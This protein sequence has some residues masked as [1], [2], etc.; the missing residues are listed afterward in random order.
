MTRFLTLSG[1]VA[2]VGYLAGALSTST[3]SVGP[4]KDRAADRGDD[5]VVETNRVDW[6]ERL[7][8]GTAAES[9]LA[10]WKLALSTWFKRGSR[11][12]NRWISEYLD[13]GPPDAMG[14]YVRGSRTRQVESR[15]G[16]G[17]FGAV[18]GN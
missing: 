1:R 7:D 16:V 15:G 17:D 12:P 2:L 10:L 11:V 3:L 9:K 14:R 8:R 13:L 6:R 5:E 4:K 18:S